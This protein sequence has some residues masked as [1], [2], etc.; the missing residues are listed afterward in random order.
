M[1]LF[2]VVSERKGLRILSHIELEG[3]DTFL[4]C[5]REAIDTFSDCP[6]KLMILCQAVMA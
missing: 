2:Q 1:I 4:D 6:G 5:K 3:E